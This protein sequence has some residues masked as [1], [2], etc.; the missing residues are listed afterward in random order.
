MEIKVHGLKEIEAQL[1][2]LGSKE[3]TKIVRASMLKASEP[4]LN[5][6][7]SNVAAIPGGSG[8]LHQ[9]LG[10][11]FFANARPVSEA[12]LPTLG[13]K[14]SVQIAPL[15]KDRKAIALYN[16]VYKPRRQ[17]KGIF[18]GHLVEFGHRIV[19]GGQ[20]RGSVPARPFLKPALDSGGTVAVA[21]FAREL[22][23]RI[24][25]QLKKNAKK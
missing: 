3:G 20:Q 4:I 22:Q 17:R 5:R 10:M 25:R 11:R 24:A 16:L 7:R 1:I 19:R 9:S 21:I 6:A 18:Y 14:M 8:A 2:A 23:E 13:G 15:R 12:G